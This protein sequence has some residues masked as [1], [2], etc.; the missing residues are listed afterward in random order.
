LVRKGLDI[1]GSIDGVRN[2]FTNNGIQKTINL[3][4][5]GDVWGTAKSAIGDIFD[6]TGGVGVLDDV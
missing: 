3:A 4:K 6:I 1:L 2:A 5:K